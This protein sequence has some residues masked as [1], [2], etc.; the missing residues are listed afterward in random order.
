LSIPAVG[1]TQP[2]GGKERTGHDA[3]PSP[4]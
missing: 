1:P 2:P 4:I 3:E